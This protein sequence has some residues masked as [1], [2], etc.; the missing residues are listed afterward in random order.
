MELIETVCELIRQRLNAYFQNIDRS[1]EDRVVLSNIVDHDGAICQGA[2]DKVVMV[3][4]NI[5]HETIVSTYNSAARTSST[6]YAIVQPPIYINLFILF[7]ANFYDRQ[8]AQGLAMISRTISFFQQNPWFTHANM[9]DLDARIDKITMEITNLDL[10]Q[11]NYLMGMLGTKY[12]PSVYYKL[13]M[14][15][16]AS[17]AMQAAVPAA[18][19]VDAPKST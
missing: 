4:T 13:R 3:L 8:Y 5:T 1:D 19:G 6:S 17:D 11:A 10:L 12:L 2:K 9:P 7:F 18:Q 15:P 14:I 16:F